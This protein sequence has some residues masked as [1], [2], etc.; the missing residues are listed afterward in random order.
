[1]SKALIKYQLYGDTPLDK[2]IL[3]YRHAL[4]TPWKILDNVDQIRAF[5]EALTYFRDSDGDDDDDEYNYPSLDSKNAKQK[6][7]IKRTRWCGE[8]EWHTHMYWCISSDGT[9]KIQITAETILNLMITKY[10]IR[11]VPN[12][13]KIVYNIQPSGR[14]MFVL[15][16]NPNT[17]SIMALYDN[18]EFKGQYDD[19]ALC[20]I[21]RHIRHKF[22]K[23]LIICTLNRMN[24]T[25]QYGSLDI[26]FDVSKLVTVP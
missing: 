1:M 19:D 24:N 12:L 21:L 13:E 20:L 10:L 17:K 25:D 11:R 5:R 6:Y 14:F 18:P 22:K 23:E 9:T 7:T 8:P 15:T 4:E 16:T 26:D 2:V 3:L